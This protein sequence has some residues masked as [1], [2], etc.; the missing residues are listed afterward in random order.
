M[1]SL[2]TEEKNVKD[3]ST[4]CRNVILKILNHIKFHV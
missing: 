2:S 1:T 4:G 3:K